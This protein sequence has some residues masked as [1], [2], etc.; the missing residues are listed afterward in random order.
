[1]VFIEAGILTEVRLVHPES[2]YWPIVVME[3]GISIEDSPEQSRNANLP[4]ETIEGGM[5][6]VVRLRHLQKVAAL[7]DVIEVGIFTDFMLL[8]L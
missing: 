3:S 7:M 5:T 8:Q 2:V 6:R 1:M 4:I